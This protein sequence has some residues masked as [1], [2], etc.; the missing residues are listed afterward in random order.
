MTDS[1]RVTRGA[2]PAYNSQ[3]AAL[4]G[5]RVARLHTLAGACAVAYNSQHATRSPGLWRSVGELRPER[6][7]LE[8][9]RSA[10]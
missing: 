1:L 8:D 6:G 5:A 7:C 3:H 4:T 10:A 2:T 9:G